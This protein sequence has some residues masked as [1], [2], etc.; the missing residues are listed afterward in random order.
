MLEYWKF[1]PNKSVICTTIETN[2]WYPEVMRNSLPPNERAAE[3][4]KL[5]F[6]F[7]T[8]VTIEPIMD[9]DLHSLIAL[10]K[11][12]KPKQVNIGADS[13]NNKIPEPSKEKIQQLINGLRSFTKVVEKSNLKRLLN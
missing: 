4:Y 6:H 11:T 3:M 8:Y 5:S 10:I 13:G 9:F 7:K 1:L 2:R 12:C